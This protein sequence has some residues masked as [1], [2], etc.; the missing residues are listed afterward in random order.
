MEPHNFGAAEGVVTPKNDDAGNRS[1]R[2]RRQG[3]ATSH[4]QNSGTTSLNQ[5]AVV[6]ARRAG[7]A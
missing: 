7:E 3:K 4:Q 5:G 1:N 2:F 6:N